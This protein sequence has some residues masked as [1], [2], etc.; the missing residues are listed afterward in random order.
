MLTSVHGNKIHIWE[1]Q[2]EKTYIG[3]DSHRQFSF[4]FFHPQFIPS[5]CL[6]Y[7][8]SLFVYAN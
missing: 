3:A 2:A 6:F 5:I 1:G 7:S 8:S 4:L